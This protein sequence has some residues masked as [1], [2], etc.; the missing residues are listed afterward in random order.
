[1]SWES[2]RR[3]SMKRTDK[4]PALRFRGFDGGWSASK[5][6]DVTTYVDYRGK[7]PP[8]SESGVFLVTAKN[9]KVGHIDYECSKEYIPKDLY[10]EVMRRGTPRLGDVLITTEA[11]LGN[12][13]TIDRIDIAL[14]QRI[15]KLRGKEKVLSSH[16]LKHLLLSPAFQRLL[17][18]RST[19]STAKGI[20]GSVLHTLP[21][22]FPS[23]TEQE[24]IAV[25]LS[26]VDLKIGLLAKKKELLLKYK[27]GVMQQIFDQK[28]RFKDDK[29]ND[30]PDWEPKELKEISDRVTKKNIANEIKF[31]L[32]NSATKGVVSQSDY[33]DKD[34]ANPNNLMGYYVVDKD[35]FVYN[36]RIST[37]APVGP[38]KRNNL[39]K[40]VMSPLY[41]VFRLKDV[42]LDFFEF[43]FETNTWHDY[44]RS[45]ANFGARHDRMNITTESFFEMPLLVPSLA[46]QDKIAKFLGTLDRKT[47][48]ADLQLEETRNFKKGLLQ[49]M[50]V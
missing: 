41:M 5:L 15:I 30:F 11:P 49:Q 24:N 21:L 35:E 38:I 32:T 14:A 33:F 29:G 36:P 27:K 31:V 4:I 17:I 10:D 16:F 44:M 18:E 43:F 2:A 25:F 13:A 26:A 42:N 46:E 12:V 45:I 47:Q 37:S 48:L 23:I 7:T 34:I 39:R 9:V 8:K 22:V 6:A 50:F 20:K 19:G 40:G 1:M 28:I 3:F